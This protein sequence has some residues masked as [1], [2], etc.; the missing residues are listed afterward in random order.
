MN[1]I[2]RNIDV[3]DE[4]YPRL[5]KYAKSAEKCIDSGE[6][7]L[8][9]I[10]L[11]RIA[12]TITKILCRRSNIPCDND[13]PDLLRKLLDREQITQSIR[14]KIKAITELHYDASHEGY[15]S[16]TS[17]RRIYEAAVQLCEWFISV[18]RFD[19]LNSLMTTE[20]YENTRYPFTKLAKFGRDTE[21]NIYSLT[22]YGL[23]CVGN[24]GEEVCMLLT[25]KF[26]HMITAEKVN[27]FR[28]LEE[29][30][31]RDIN[32]RYIAEQLERDDPNL[33]TI[34]HRVRKLE[35]ALRIKFLLHCGI[36]GEEQKNILQNMLEPRNG[37]VHGEI[38]IDG[39][40]ITYY[41][42]RHDKFN[43]NAKKLLND[44]QSL[45]VWLFRKF[46]HAGCIFTGRVESINANS[47]RVSSG[48]V[49]GFVSGENILEGHECETGK[50]YPFDVVSVEGNRINL[51]MKWMT[52]ARRYRAYH[53]DQEVRAVV[54]SVEEGHGVNVEIRDG[55]EE[56]L[57]AFIPSF[58]MNNMNLS[59]GRE[60]NAKVKGFT[61]GKPY[62]F[63]TMKDVVQDEREDIEAITEI[64]EEEKH[65]L[66]KQFLRICMSGTEEEIS[67]AISSG[68][69]INVRNRSQATGLM[70]AA[71]RN[72]AHAVEIL[73]DAGLDIDMQDI[74][75]NTALIYAASYNNDDVVDM[76]IGKGAEV[77][78]INHT[79]HKALNFARKNYRLNDTE[80]LRVLEE[81]TKN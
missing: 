81:Q 42:R 35:Q 48:P 13:E 34:A 26:I 46:I 5:E 17:C 33:K 9:M 49:Y 41:T 72:T 69:N 37:A 40:N 3:F 43:M 14:Q 78:I 65:E 51:G 11:G 58:E 6:Y 32:L 80:A 76:L 38:E 8:C 20:R 68:V 54:V 60:I 18:Q 75:G 59:E 63:L 56:G 2:R 27:E 30:N 4:N 67:R 39:D 66:Q 31:G 1:L 73:I 19:F 64:T 21:N 52:L 55:Q 36:I 77:N 57:G 70:F 22:R 23:L 50:V 15:N 12:E 44:T 10:Y 29:A 7:N 53:N 28:T 74:H 45:C 47:I 62:M 16:K 71:Q 79:G 61:V 24:M 25:F